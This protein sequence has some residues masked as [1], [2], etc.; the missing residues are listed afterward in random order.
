MPLVLLVLLTGLL[1]PLSCLAAGGHHAVD[2][3][4]IAVPGQCNLE[5]WAERS[6]L[7]RRQRQHAGLGCYVLGVEAEINADRETAQPVPNL[8]AHAVQLKWATDLR[9][10]LAIGLVG[11]LSWQDQAPRSQRSLLVPLSWTPRDDLAL[12]LN[13]GRAFVRG[14]EDRTQ[15]GIAVEWQMVAGWQLLVEHFHD[16]LRPMSRLGLRHDVNERLSLDLSFAR[17]SATGRGPKEGWWTAGV[18]W[19]LGQ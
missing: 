15:R 3:A 1:L 6:N 7:D 10:R 2:D 12:H 8:H 18:N 4:V 5:L 14:G 11:A 13:L 9:P 17:A 19:T 16:G